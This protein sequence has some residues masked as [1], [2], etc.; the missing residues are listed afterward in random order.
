M[1]LITYSQTNK[2]VCEMVSSFYRRAFRIDNTLCPYF[3]LEEITCFREVQA[4]T[5]DITWLQ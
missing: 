5:G 1:E 2:S 4:I 3:T